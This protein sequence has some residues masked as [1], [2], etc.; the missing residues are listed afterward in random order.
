MLLI[1]KIIEVL[2]QY[3]KMT[4]D[5]RSHTD[6]RQTHQYNEILSQKRAQSTLEYMVRNGI[7]KE[8]LTAKGYGETQLL[9]NC[10]DGVKCSEEEHQQNR[11]S[12][13]IITKVE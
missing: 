1:L 6:S 2:K 7:N 13:F 10:V 5:I 8:R 12:E 3:P 11:R 9:N 4:I